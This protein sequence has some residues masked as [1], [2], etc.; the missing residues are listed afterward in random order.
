MQM[1]FEKDVK[2]NLESFK[3]I[4]YPGRG[5]IIG[6]S[7]DSNF[8]VQIYW[9]AG[10][11]ENSQNRVIINENGFIK[12][13]AYIDKEL[14]NPSLIIYYAAKDLGPYHIISNGEQ[15]D[16][17][18]DSLLANESFESAINQW[19]FEHDPPLYTPRIS[20]LV[21]VNNKKNSYKLSINKSINN[22]P[23]YCIRNFYTYE[24]A[25]PGIGHCIHTYESIGDS[26]SSFNGEPFMLK[27]FNDIDKTI[28]YYW[29]ILNDDIKVAMYVKFINI[30]TGKFEF[31]L[32]NRHE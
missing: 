23:N 28:D 1:L 32:K 19:E 9:T 4:Y 16:T 29:K 27:T 31:R 30:Q 11:S 26:I 6:M 10:R 15:T 3:N 20:G 13:K 21:D 22:D 2:S 7:P 14:I 5:I 17:I 18:Y 25:V 8:M 12:T 24:T